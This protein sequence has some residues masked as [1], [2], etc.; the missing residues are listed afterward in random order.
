MNVGDIVKIKSI[1]G[2]RR[3]ITN[4]DALFVYVENSNFP[5]VES[6]LEIHE[7]QIKLNNRLQKLKQIGI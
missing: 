3:I 2:T 1:P 5:F 4:I 6:E 7:D